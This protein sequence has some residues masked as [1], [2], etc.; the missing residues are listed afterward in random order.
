MAT[1][2]A[3]G[4]GTPRAAAEDMLLHGAC[5]PGDKQN[6][7]L[8]LTNNEHELQLCN[9][10][11]E[12][13]RAAP[14]KWKNRRPCQILAQTLGVP[15]CA[16]GY[17]LDSGTWSVPSVSTS[18]H[19][20]QSSLPSFPAAVARSRA[21]GLPGPDRWHCWRLQGEVRAS[22]SQPA[23]GDHCERGSELRHQHRNPKAQCRARARRREPACAPQHA[24][25]DH[26]QLAR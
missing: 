7:A 10:A 15:Y 24:A 8:G 14:R 3:E 19:E 18:S 4:G 12:V 23:V 17:R 11:F 25:A 22:R 5:R 6:W 20:K 13:E 1:A 2:Q 26:R 21:V 16:G 9:S